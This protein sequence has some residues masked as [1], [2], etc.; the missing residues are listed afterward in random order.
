M[1]SRHLSVELAAPEVIVLVALYMS[2]SWID[3]RPRSARYWVADVGCTLF[4]EAFLGTQVCMLCDPGTCLLG[5][6]S[7]EIEDM[8][9]DMELSTI[10]DSR[11]ALMV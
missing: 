4:F 2:S 3:D 1:I 11:D 5:I 6:D 8:M 9:E 10:K 7:Q